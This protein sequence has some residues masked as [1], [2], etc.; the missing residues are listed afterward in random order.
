MRI[1]RSRVQNSRA[2]KRVVTF[3]RPS[4][5]S[6]PWACVLQLVLF[7]KTTEMAFCAPLSARTL[8]RVTTLESSD[9]SRL[10]M[11]L[12]LAR[13]RTQVAVV[14]ALADEV[15]LLVSPNVEATLDSNPERGLGEQLVEETAH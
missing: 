6:P 13:L 10:A 1:T 3:L 9:D 8:P 11:E 2:A 12:R 4:F 15:E 7:M 14:R 5:G